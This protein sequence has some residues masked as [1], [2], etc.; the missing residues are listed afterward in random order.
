MFLLDTAGS[1]LRVSEDAQVQQDVLVPA[2]V[3]LTGLVCWSVR[4]RNDSYRCS[5]Q[6]H[7]G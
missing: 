1:L 2:V 3:D 4:G 7:C 5:V 6:A